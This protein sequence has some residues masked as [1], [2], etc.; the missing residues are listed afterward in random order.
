MSCQF[1]QSNRPLSTEEV[2]RRINSS[3]I[4]EKLLKILSEDQGYQFVSFSS[5]KHKEVMEKINEES[6]KQV[7]ATNSIEKEFP[8]T[9]ERIFKEQMIKYEIF[10]IHSFD[11]TETICLPISTKVCDAHRIFSTLLYSVDKRKVPVD[12]ADY[13]LVYENILISYEVQHNELFEELLK[14]SFRLN[15]IGLS[16]FRILVI[17]K[18][19]LIILERKE[20]KRFSN[21]PI[22][23]LKL[24][25]FHLFPMNL[26]ELSSNENDFRKTF[27]NNKD[28]YWPFMEIKMGIIPSAK[29]IHPFKYE[30][31]REFIAETLL[32]DN[33]LNNTQITF[34]NCM[35]ILEKIFETFHTN[36]ICLKSMKSSLEKLVD[37]YDYPLLIAL[38]Y[39]RLF[40]SQFSKIQSS[41]HRL[42]QGIMTNGKYY[43]IQNNPFTSMESLKI[44][45]GSFIHLRFNNQLDTI[46]NRNHSNETIKF[47]ESYEYK[48]GSYCSIEIDGNSVQLQFSS[49]IMNFLLSNE[50]TPFNGTNINYL[51]SH[52]KVSHNWINNSTN[53]NQSIVVPTDETEDSLRD[54]FRFLTLTNSPSLCS[55]SICE[56][57]ECF[58][59]LT[60]LS[61]EDFQCPKC[62]Q[63]FCR[64]CIESN[65]SENPQSYFCPKCYSLNKLFDYQMSNTIGKFVKIGISAFQCVK[66]GSIPEQ[67][68]ICR[69]PKCATLICYPCCSNETTNE[70]DKCPKCRINDIYHNTTVSYFIQKI[71]LYDRIKNRD[72]D[73]HSVIVDDSIPRT[74]WTEED[75]RPRF[76][77]FK[78][79]FDRI[80]SV[81]EFDG[82][83][84]EFP[85]E[86]QSRPKLIIN[87]PYEYSCPESLQVSYWYDHPDKNCWEN[88]K[89]TQFYTKDQS[90]ISTYIS[91]F[92]KFTIRNTRLVD[93]IMLDKALLNIVYDYDF[94]LENG[95][96]R[97]EYRGPERYFRPRGWYRIAIDV[98]RKY[99][100]TAWLGTNKNAWP[101]A[102]HGTASDN[103]RKIL[104]NGLLAGGSQ[105]IQ[106]SN[107]EVH[108]KGIYLSPYSTYS[109]SESYAKPL[110][111]D[112]K[113]YQVIFQVR[114]ESSQI[115]KTE[116]RFVWVCRNPSAIRPYGILYREI[117]EQHNT[118]V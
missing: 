9:I 80:I 22:S 70:I 71:L 79:N 108:G 39:D 77:N 85:G 74:M 10:S 54:H 46:L 68:R 30:K 44:N 5:K 94:T 6:N 104:C 47:N 105:G 13:V 14:I 95:V 64:Q 102:Y 2:Q 118:H 76:G 50:T 57:P 25:L 23:I 114:V 83:H 97:I 88:D 1:G 93:F 27:S 7:E 37:V 20:T 28:Y 81:I 48:I 41:D 82:N 112:G 60:P 12:L 43:S 111:M 53:I 45:R 36:S 92:S 75:W 78:E 58:N 107:G 56:K 87:E 91:H 72:I 35:K 63:V 101:V 65:P 109:G 52:I 117:N 98:L 103:A 84:I 69:D 18:S 62:T 67:H 49:D 3:K 40:L 99:K 51:R 34:E 16:P 90:T 29:L 26:I 100:D 38:P 33:S 86:I 66:C 61:D 8:K 32:V 31:L 17:H 11:Q 19:Q 24:I 42:A 15:R 21:E 89:T 113:R 4:C 115:I 59:C 106:Q 96:N 116:D 110:T 73:D 55:L